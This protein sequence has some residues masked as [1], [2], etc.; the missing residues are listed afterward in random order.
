MTLTLNTEATGSFKTL[1]VTYQIPE[2][3]NLNNFTVIRWGIV[4]FKPKIT[5]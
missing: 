4:T 5:N 2:D 3:H 1:V